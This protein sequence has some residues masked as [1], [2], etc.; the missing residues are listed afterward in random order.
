VPAGTYQFRPGRVQVEKHGDQRQR[1]G[2][3]Q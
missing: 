2:Q 1:G 3:I